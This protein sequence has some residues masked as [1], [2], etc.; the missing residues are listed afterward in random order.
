MLDL[1]I[2][3]F[4]KDH[5]ETEHSRL[6]SDLRKAISDIPRELCRTAQSEFF[7]PPSHSNET[8]V[9]EELGLARAP[10]VRQSQRQLHLD[11]IQQ[12]RT[13]G[14]HLFLLERR[15]SP[16]RRI[17]AIVAQI[18][19]DSHSVC[20]RSLARSTAGRRAIKQAPLSVPTG[21]CAETNFFPTS[22]Q[23]R[24][25]SLATKPFGLDQSRADQSR[26]EQSRLDC[27]LARCTTS[28]FAGNKC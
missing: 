24:T 13:S 28:Q 27:D 5:L 11:V 21:R 22:F 8:R 10:R 3:P 17:A 16:S 23:K 12:R 1:R 2:N 15:A 9:V 26:A 4:S 7:F 20:L 18:L 6:R 25:T 19:T 14:G